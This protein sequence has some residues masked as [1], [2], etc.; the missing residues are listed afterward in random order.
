MILTQ[1]EAKEACDWLK[2]AGFPQYAQLY[3]DSRFP[4]DIS[5][6][7]RDHDFLDHDAIDALCR[8][9]NTLNKCAVMRLEISRQRKRS[10]DSDEDEPCAISGLWTP[11]GPSR[12]GPLGPE[13][14]SGGGLLVPQRQQP[15]AG[16]TRTSSVTS[17]CSSGASAANDDSLSEGPPELPARSSSR[18]AGG[19]KTSRSKAKSFLKRMESLRLRGAGSR[20]KRRAGQG[21]GPGRRSAARSCA[22]SWTRTSCGGSTAWDVAALNALNALNGR[23]RSV[24]HP[25][26]PGP[27]AAA[28]AGTSSAGTSAGSSQSEASSGS[29]VSTPSPVAGA[30]EGA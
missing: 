1:I 6:V 28:A 11:A 17:D 27:A 16:T 8:R 9:L 23:S 4:I 24:S 7:T 13:R 25:C 2:A 18:P 14:A 12:D 22:A 29:A 30:G 5:S 3:E 21:R 15:G 20:R 26:P 19:A 10:E